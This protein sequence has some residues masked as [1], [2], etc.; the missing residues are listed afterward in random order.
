MGNSQDIFSIE[1]IV[2]ILSVI[3]F[4]YRAIVLM[5]PMMKQSIEK[6]DMRQFMNSLTLL[7]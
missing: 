2:G 4:V 6:K 5:Y 1:L 7:V 3:I